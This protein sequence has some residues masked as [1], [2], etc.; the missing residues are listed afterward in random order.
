M[1]HVVSSDSSSIP[2]VLFFEYIQH[3]A[4]RSH[5][6]DHHNDMHLCTHR[7]VESGNDD[8]EQAA[9]TGGRV[10][11]H[12]VTRTSRKREQERHEERHEEREESASPARNTR[13]QVRASNKRT[14]AK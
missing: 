12:T 14:K 3:H 11:G 5:C 8:T 6:A 2:N 4:Y 1:C 13:A 9:H 10:D 7:F